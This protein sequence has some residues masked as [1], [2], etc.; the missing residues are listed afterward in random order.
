MIN[1]TKVNR[2]VARKN[3]PTALSISLLVILASNVANTPIFERAYAIKGFNIDVDIEDNKIK[4]GDTQHVTVTVIN[5]DTDNRVSNANVKLTVF[6]LD[7]DPTS[8]DDETDNN[9]EATFDVEI[10]NNAETG[11]YDVDIRVS[12]DGYD[13]KT[14]NASFDVVKSSGAD[15]EDDED[16]NY[17]GS[18]SSQF[19]LTTLIMALQNTRQELKKDIELRR[20]VEFNRKSGSIGVSIPSEWCQDLGLTPK[21]YVKL[22]RDSTGF[23]VEKISFK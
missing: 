3:F 23:R 9:G 13:T 8:A 10:D 1:N 11:T 7:G 4:R 5:D 14:V 17:N 6:P 20:L 15:D 12:K 19:L 16:E 18:S 22:E 21:E 2:H